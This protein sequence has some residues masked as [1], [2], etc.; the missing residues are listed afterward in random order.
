MNNIY[1]PQRSNKRTM[2][3]NVTWMLTTTTNG[4]FQCGTYNLFSTNTKEIQAFVD[5]HGSLT[6]GFAIA[7]GVNHATGEVYEI[8]KKGY[9]ARKDFQILV[10]KGCTEFLLDNAFAGKNFQLANTNTIVKLKET[11][12]INP[13]T[14]TKEAMRFINVFGG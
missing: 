6:H 2:T 14:I 9:F 8:I 5:N 7:Y 1:I 11:I 3:N 10:N 4:F 12:E 13:K